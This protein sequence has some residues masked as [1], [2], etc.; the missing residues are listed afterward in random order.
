[1]SA[2]EIFPIAFAALYVGHH[3]GDYW[4]QTDHQAAHKGDAGSEGRDA[5]LRHVAGYVL[6]QQ[7]AVALTF[8]VLGLSVNVVGWCVAFAV[9]GITHYMAD[10]REHGLMFWLARR[11]PGNAQF[12]QLGVPRSTLELELWEPCPECEG[13]GTSYDASTGGKCWD[14][15]G[16]G[17]LPGVALITD[18]PSLGTGRWALDQSWHLFF[19]VFLAALIIA[20]GA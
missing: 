2:A 15:K 8:V 11:V 16:G 14:C 18:N 19:G 17:M 20:G 13:R 9:S 1:M 3:V 10:R 12:F 4:V 6:T 7:A 5:C